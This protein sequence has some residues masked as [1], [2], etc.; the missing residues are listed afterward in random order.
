MFVIFKIAIVHNFMRFRHFFVLNEADPAG[1]PPGGPPM[2]GPPGLGGPPMGGPPGLGGPPMGGPPGGMGAA[3]NEPPTI[4]KNADVWDVLD[5]ILNKKPLEHDKK[6][7]AQ[8]S[9]QDAQQDPMASTM[10][11]ATMMGGPALM[12]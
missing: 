10:D 9:A 8:S 11:P 2:G 3:P 12:S 7:Q 6:I 5:H 1:A 4:P